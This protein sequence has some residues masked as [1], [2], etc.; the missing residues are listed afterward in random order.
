M[1]TLPHSLDRLEVL[2]D[3]ER[4]V[5][6]AGLI[7]SATLAEYL[8]LRELFDGWVDLGDA[9]G[10]A[11]VGHKAMTVVHSVLAGAD[12][13]DDCD[14]LRAGATAL[15]LGHA[16]A[17]PSTVG[18]FLW[19]FHLGPR[20]PAGQGGRRV[21]GPGVG[22]RGG[23][24]R[25]AAHHRLGL[26]D[27]RDLRVGQAR[28]MEV[29]LQPCP[30]LSASLR[31]YGRQR[32]RVALPLARRQRPDHS[33]RGGVF[34]RDLQPG[35]SR[36]RH[37]PADR[38][39]RLGFYTRHVFDACRRGDVRFSITA[40]L[41]KGG[42]HNAIAFHRRRRLDTD[43]AEATYQLDSREHFRTE[44]LVNLLVAREQPA[45][46]CSGV[47]SMARDPLSRRSRVGSSAGNGP[48]LRVAD[49]VPMQST[50]SCWYSAFAG[51]EIPWRELTGMP[52][53]L[54][55]R[56]RAILS[57]PSDR[58]NPAASPVPPR[59]EEVTRPRATAASRP[60]GRRPVGMANRATGAAV[61]RVSLG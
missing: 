31:G 22:V 48:A 57:S 23:S 52:G 12:S 28:R 16:V 45:H 43:V 49:A 51:A 55:P 21:V 2:F 60:H 25:R 61:L 29:H 37:R 14:V 41:R 36:R 33:G 46:H 42:V 3:D 18:T 47:R 27:P 53:P 7:A 40:K 4:L 38:A 59:L 39:S 13:I 56:M 44:R 5:A 54:P 34:D 15:V 50:P 8:G 9:P 10:H 19:S 58:M 30:R 11:N 20:P 17:A 32:R 6:N 1:R 24:G 35:P 26:V